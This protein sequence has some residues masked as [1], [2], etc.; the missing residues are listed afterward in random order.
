ME[1]DS[2]HPSRA[3]TVLTE[4]PRVDSYSVGREITRSDE[5]LYHFSSPP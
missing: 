2:G 4:K 3:I 1:A 5:W